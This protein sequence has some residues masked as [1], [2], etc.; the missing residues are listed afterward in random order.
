MLSIYP[1]I[2]NSIGVVK[3]IFYRYSSTRT[4]VLVLELEG[5][6]DIW[7]P[8]VFD[9]KRDIRAGATARIFRQASAGVKDKFIIDRILLH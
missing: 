2:V 1:L 9:K 6:A 4:G 7:V 3:Y 8:H 5:L